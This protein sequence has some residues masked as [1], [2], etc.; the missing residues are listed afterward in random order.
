MNDSDSTRR[1]IDEHLPS[2]TQPPMTPAEA[3]DHLTRLHACGCAEY[4]FMVP[5]KA[6]RC[7]IHQV[8]RDSGPCDDAAPPERLDEALTVL[9]R[10]DVEETRRRELAI[11][12][13]GEP[14]NNPNAEGSPDA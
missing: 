10:A 1:A 6:L 2:L 3:Q 7:P 12:S 9:L 13:P 4:W 8:N 14:W 5:A 11:E